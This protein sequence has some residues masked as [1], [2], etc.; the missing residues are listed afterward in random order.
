[1]SL[2][3]LFPR[4]FVRRVL[5]TQGIPLMRRSFPFGSVALSGALFALLVVGCGH[6]ISIPDWHTISAANKGD[7]GSEKPFDVLVEELPPA[8]ADA[9]EEADAGT[10]GTV[11]GTGPCPAATM[12]YEAPAP[13]YSAPR[14]Q[15]VAPLVS[16]MSNDDK[17]KQMYGVPDPNN[18]DV[19]YGNIEQS[20]DVT[21][22]SSGQLLRGLKYR[23]AGRGVNLDARQPNNRPTQGHDYSTAFPTE[24]ARAASWDVDNEI[25]VGE[26]MGDEVMGSLNN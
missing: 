8:D 16:G 15:A 11:V 24:S 7:A 6:A 2:A 4:I 17:F 20:L 19:A 9:G 26:A 12:P 10:T 25:A 18:R 3:N 21:D 5:N 13:G 23:D 22:L 1:M 14:D